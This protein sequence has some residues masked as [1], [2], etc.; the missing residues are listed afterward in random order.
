MATPESEGFVRSFARGLSVLTALGKG[1]GQHT[2][3]SVAEA[4]GLARSAVRRILLTL[5]ELRYAET[6]GKTF[7]LTP[8]VLTLGLSYISSLPYLNHAQH[9]IQ[10]LSAEVEESCAI[11]VMDDTE[12]VFVMRIPSRRVMS[13]HLGIGSRLPAYATSSGR[14]FLAA[15]DEATLDRYFAEITPRSFTPR[16]VTDRA[17]LV[18]ILAEVRETGHAW[19]DREF[20]NSVASLAVAIRGSGDSVTAALSIHFLAAGWTKEKALERFLTPLRHAAESIE[21]D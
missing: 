7:H 6:D 17:A 8:R 21:F 9:A 20:D 18:A 14:I 4:T 16:T 5:C 3:A 15:M 11:A 10:E 2:I 19:V 1:H 13:V 12:A